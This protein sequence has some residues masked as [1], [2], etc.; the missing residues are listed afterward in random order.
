MK[1][2]H[3]PLSQGSAENVYNT[4]LLLWK[5]GCFVLKENPAVSMYIFVNRDF[6]LSQA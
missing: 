1:A 2:E 4:H 6:C 3:N 5:A